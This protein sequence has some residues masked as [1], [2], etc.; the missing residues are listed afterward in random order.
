MLD[1]EVG[2]KHLILVQ[3]PAAQIIWDF[4]I[5]RVVILIYRVTTYLIPVN[6]S[7]KDMHVYDNLQFE[8]VPQ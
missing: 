7:R 6:E 4:G 3:N 5:E 1:I 2:H 8:H